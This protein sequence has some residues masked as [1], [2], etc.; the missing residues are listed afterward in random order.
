MG[1]SAQSAPAVVP[2]P[3]AFASSELRITARCCRHDL[4][5][6]P[7]EASIEEL[8]ERWMIVRK[9]VELRATAPEG[10]ETFRSAS[11]SDVFTLHA[12][13]ERGA[14]WFDREYAVV[15]L[16]GFATHREGDRSDSYA[17]LRSLDE[18]ELL[19]PAEEDY[20]QL[21][22]DRDARQIPE[23]IAEV[24]ALLFRARAE[25]DEV[26]AA[27]LN[28]GVTLR[29]YVERMEEEG[30]GVEEFHLAVSLKFLGRKML[31]HIRAALW[32]EDATASW[33]FTRDFPQSGDDE[34]ELRFR[35]WHDLPK[36]ADADS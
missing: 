2:K 8:A 34:S 18:R 32:P 15:W 23:M 6:E 31:S 11:R 13:R 5:V 30:G 12:A 7:G 19:M 26:H 20:E 21:I 9:F 33:E 4:G 27:M 24:R 1:R 29:L 22:R 25:P 28:N 10:N 17:Y 36:D 16:L 3:P 35:H 14:T